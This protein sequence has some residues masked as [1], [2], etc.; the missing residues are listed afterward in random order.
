MNAHSTLA[1]TTL[2][3]VLPALAHAHLDLDDPPSRYGRDELKYSPCGITGGRRSDI[4]TTLESGATIEIQWNEYIDHPGHYRIAFDDDGDD[5]FA[6]PVC[7]ENCDSRTD[8]TPPTFQFD[9]ALPVLMDGIADRNTFGRDPS[10]TATVTLPDVECE[11]CTLQVIQ[12]MYDK[13]PYTS[14]LT[15]DDVYYQCADLVLR[16]A[17][18][19][20]GPR[21]D[22]PTSDSGGPDGGPATMTSDGGCACAAGG[23]QQ[24]GLWGAAIGLTVC[25]L[26]LRRRH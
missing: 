20:G 11:N 19:D 2:V 7:L 17:A 16:R 4:V 21:A 8:P 23:R 15:S 14:G 3:F 24:P 10:Y 6:E 18:T 22:G 9:T 13:R 25:L 1:A 26:L 12:V 5:A